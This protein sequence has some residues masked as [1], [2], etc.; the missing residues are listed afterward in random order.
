MQAS[1]KLTRDSEN[2]LILLMP[3]MQKI[4]NLQEKSI[5]TK[6]Y[7]TVANHALH[8]SSEAFVSNGRIELTHYYLE[9]SI[10]DSFHRYGNLGLKAIK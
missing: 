1:D 2:D 9:Q 5:S 3:K 10:S 8:I 4:R 6:V 7:E